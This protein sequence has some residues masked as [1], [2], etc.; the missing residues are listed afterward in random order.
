MTKAITEESL[1]RKLVIF[2]SP[3]NEVEMSKK[4]I[5]VEFKEPDPD[6]DKLAELYQYC[7]DNFS[8]NW[9]WSARP[10]YEFVRIYFVHPE[11]AL[12]FKLML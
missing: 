9:I 1:R 7:Q 3:R 11:D 10:S 6:N 8:D 5:Y 4:Y 2:G 12:Q